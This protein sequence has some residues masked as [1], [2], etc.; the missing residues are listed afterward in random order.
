MCDA[1]VE[2]GRSRGRGR[3]LGDGGKGRERKSYSG[4]H[5]LG[6][7]DRS[8]YPRRWIIGCMVHL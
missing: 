4:S 1:S 8:L 3:E 2:N 5:I 6:L 7:I